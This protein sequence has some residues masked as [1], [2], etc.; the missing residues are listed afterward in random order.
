MDRLCGSY[1]RKKMALDGT[2][3]EVAYV[4]QDFSS[5]PDFYKVPPQRTKPFGTVHA[6]LCAADVVQ[7]PCCVINADDY[8]GAGAYQTMYETLQ[9]LAQEGQAAMVAYQL[10][11]TASLHGAVSRGIC[12]V[13]GEWLTGVKETKNIQLYPDGRIRDL[14]ADSDLDPESV[15]SMNFWGFMPSVFPVL[16]EYFHAFLHEIAA[17]DLT[18]ECL[19]PVMVDSL[20]KQNR[21][22]VRVLSSADQWFGMTYQEDR[23]AVSGEILRL[24]RQGAYPETLK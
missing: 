3:V 12:S 24:H 9:H 13:E 4:C 15:V 7:E 21:L 17:E 14:R 22:E 20:L 1:L 6:L 2:P 19:L 11:K 23:A 8:Y 10:S 18:A 16:Q 5:I